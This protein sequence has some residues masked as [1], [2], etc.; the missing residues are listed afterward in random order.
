MVSLVLLAQRIDG[1]LT[2]VEFAASSMSF[3]VQKLPA[4]PRPARR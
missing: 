3:L 1:G 2:P 4:P